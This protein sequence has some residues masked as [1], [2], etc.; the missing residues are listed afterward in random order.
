[1]QVAAVIFFVSYVIDIMICLEQADN[2]CVDTC[3]PMRSMLLFVKAHHVKIYPV[4]FAGPTHKPL[5]I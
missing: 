5:Q 3:L 1:M 2:W 4:V